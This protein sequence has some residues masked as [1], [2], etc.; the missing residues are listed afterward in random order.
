MLEDT[1]QTLRDL[2][3]S[4]PEVRRVEAERVALDLDGNPK[5]VPVVRRDMAAIKAAAEK[6]GAA[7]E[8]TISAL[9]YNDAAIEEAADPV[10]RNGA[11][12]LFT[13]CLSQLC[14]RGRRR[15]PQVWASRA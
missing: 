5:V 14:Q 12:W 11:D 15:G 8:A 4:F 3:A 2:L 10:E 7:T 13:A 9:G 1:W 6:S